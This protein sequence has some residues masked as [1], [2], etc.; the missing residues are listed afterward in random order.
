MHAAS[1]EPAASEIDAHI[2]NNMHDID[3]SA[4]FSDD[5]T[6]AAQLNAAKRDNKPAKAKT[7]QSANDGSLEGEIESVI[8][9]YEDYDTDRNQDNGNV[10][11]DKAGA[12]AKEKDKQQKRIQ[13]IKDMMAVT[14][15][16]ILGLALV[17]MLA[18]VGRHYIGPAPVMNAASSQTDLEMLVKRPR[19]KNKFVK[20]KSEFVTFKDEEKPGHLRNTSYL[21][22]SEPDSDAAF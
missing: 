7:V 14:L 13:L 12:E 18:C 20:S 16:A 8:E 6:L 22:T 11:F 9:Q 17:I 2:L 1:T 21:S 19:K 3:F 15:Y 5:A 10:I 4:G